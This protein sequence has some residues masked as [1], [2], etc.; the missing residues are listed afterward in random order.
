MSWG[1]E[2]VKI[3]RLLRDPNATIW[4]DNFLKNLY[5]DIQRDFQHQT[6]VLEDVAAQRVPG[7]YHFSYMQ[8]W[9]YRYLPTKYSQFYQC[10]SKHDESVFCHR[11]EPQQTAG[12]SA[13]ISDDGSHFTHPWE[14]FMSPPG[15]VVRMKFPSNMRNI[16]FIAYD[17]EPIDLT[18]RKAVQSRDSSFR[19]TEGRPF[20]YYET[21]DLDDSYVLYPRPSTSFV[22]DLSGEGVAFYEDD[23]TEDITTGTI[24]V[25]TGDSESD[26]IGAAV[27]IVGTVDNVFIAY[28]VTPTPI[29]TTSDEGDYP[30]YLK[31]YIR[32]GVVSRAYGANNDGRIVSLSVYWGLR[33]DLGVKHTKR[34]VRSKRQDRDYRLRTPATVRSRRRHP[35]LPSTYP[36]VQP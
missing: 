17:E 6:S 22:D 18:T 36:D 26:N 21:S 25:R 2:L 13:D 14:A 11:W 33:Y 30:E 20:A 16:K 27:D 3:R 29:R 12:I 28:D 9:E 34:L 31:K 7:L 15:E 32:Y 8:D 10:L 19:T 1:D 23:D 4:S 24:A 5:N 35:R